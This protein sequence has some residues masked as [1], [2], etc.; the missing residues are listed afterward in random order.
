VISKPMGAIL[1]F[2]VFAGLMF[3]G[4]AVPAL[5]AANPA[6]DTRQFSVVS[7]LGACAIFFR[8]GCLVFGGGPVVVPLLLLDL[9]S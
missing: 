4:F 6:Q 3:M 9:T 8:A 1:L 2:I 5:Q 7:A